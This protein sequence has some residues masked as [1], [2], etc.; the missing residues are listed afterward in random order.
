MLDRIMHSNLSHIPSASHIFFNPTTIR[1]RSC[2]QLGR[3]NKRRVFSS[4]T[5]STCLLKEITY[6]HSV[7]NHASKHTA[8]PKEKTVL[9]RNFSFKLFA[10]TEFKARL[11]EMIIV[12]IVLQS[13]KRPMQRKTVWSSDR[14]N[15]DSLQKLNGMSISWN[16]CSRCFGLFF[17]GVRLCQLGYLTKSTISAYPVRIPQDLCCQAAAAF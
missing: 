15:L 1:I 4:K 16:V 7:S 3:L 9:F 10:R 6:T 14:S 12:R 17:F 13:K 8:K 11:E 2:H 5:W